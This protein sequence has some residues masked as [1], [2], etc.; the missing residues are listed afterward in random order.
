ME[1]VRPRTV[2]VSHHPFRNFVAPKTKGKVGGP[3]NTKIF[4]KELE[5]LNVLLGQL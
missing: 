3:S 2:I 1:V 5:V 4:A